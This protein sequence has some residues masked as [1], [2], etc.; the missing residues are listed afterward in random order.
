MPPALT[1]PLDGVITCGTS[2]A[3][4]VTLRFSC[5]RCW[6]IESETCVVTPWRVAEKIDAS[7]DAT[8]CTP[9]RFTAV[10]ASLKSTRT[11]C[12]SGTTMSFLSCVSKPMRLVLTVYGPPVSHDRIHQHG[13]DPKQWV[14]PD[15]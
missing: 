11:V 1:P 5:G 12:D 4:S 14:L 6:M 2:L 15:S 10:C 8:T 7:L 9:V 3:M 13:S